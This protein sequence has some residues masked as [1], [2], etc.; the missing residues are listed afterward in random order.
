MN[1]L[2][3]IPAISAFIYI[4]LFVITASNRPL[5]RN[6][7]LFLFMLV[8]ATC[9][10]VSDFLMRSPFFNDYKLLLLRLVVITSLCW[11]IQFYIF[12]RAFL[13]APR[14]IGVYLGYAMLGVTTVLCIVGAIPLGIV[15]DNWEARAISGW[16]LV[17]W[18]GPMVFLAI[19]AII[20]LVKRLMTPNSP[21]DRNK[22]NYLICSIALLAVFGIP[23]VAPQAKFISFGSIGGI[24]CASVL[25]YSVV[26]HDLISISVF[27]R[28]MLGLVVLFV[29][30]VVAFELVQLVGHFVAG[31]VLTPVMIISSAIG[32]LIVSA[33]LFWLRTFFMEKIEQLFNRQRYQYRQELFDFV[34]H[35]M[36]G[37]RDLQE[38]GEG[39]LSPLV[40]TLDCRQAYILLPERSSENFVIR[41]SEPSPDSLSSLHIRKDSPIIGY[42]HNQYLTKKDLDISA[43]LRGI[44]TSERTDLHNSGIELMFPLLNRGNMVGILALGKKRSGKYSIEDANLVES[45]ANQVAVSLEKERFHNQLAK[46]EKELSIIN[47]LTRVLTSSLNI[48]D[49]YDIFIA[50]LREAVD[51]D[52]AAI[53]II[54]NDKMQNL[55]SL[56]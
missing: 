19:L 46:R 24:L 43:E 52:F 37:V 41:F 45:I 15:V 2:H 36:R 5:T 50:G 1:V 56:S 51:I 16:W 7:R 10:S 35:K 6:H 48:Q 33:I 27:L 9:W 22:L 30:S 32:T 42:L 38:L 14:D 13:N 21:E 11:V 34:A 3:Y 12:L 44:W 4:V 40:K 28:R 39:L 55:G 29:I 8:P 25:A 31:L 18:V 49:V 17:F 23:S 54:E 26:K 20:M 47:R 53:G